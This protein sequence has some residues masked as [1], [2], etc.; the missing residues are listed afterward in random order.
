MFIK[1]RVSKRTTLG[2]TDIGELFD[3]ML[4]LLGFDL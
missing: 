1:K 2:S 3:G 4:N